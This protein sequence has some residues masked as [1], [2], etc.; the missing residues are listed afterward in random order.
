MSK[1]N[2]NIGNV[3]L[4]QKLINYL[5]DLKAKNKFTDVIKFTLENVKSNDLEL[6]KAFFIY[7]SY[8]IYLDKNIE[9]K[10]DFVKNFMHNIY[11]D[12]KWELLKMIYSQ[13]L[14][15]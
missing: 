7:L 12:I 9:T 6:I 10:I 2:Y 13:F 8:D 15:Y 11:K 4:C 1:D 14:F 3:I 5:Y